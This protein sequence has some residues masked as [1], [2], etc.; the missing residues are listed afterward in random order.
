MIFVSVLYETRVRCFI[1]QDSFKRQSNRIV[2][3]TDHIKMIF[4]TFVHESRVILN[5]N[6]QGDSI[7]RYDFEHDVE[8]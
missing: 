6:L 5:Y 7:T 4:V 2:S 1:T 3:Q 8:I